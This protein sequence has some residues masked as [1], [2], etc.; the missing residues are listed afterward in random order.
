LHYSLT[1]SFLCAGA[2]SH[3]H[4]LGLDQDGQPKTQADG[5]VGQV[6]ARKA[7]GVVL[8]MIKESKI[9]GRGI[10]LAGQPGSGKTALAMGKWRSR[11]Q[12][13]EKERKKS[14][15]TSFFLSLYMRTKIC[16]PFQPRI[17]T[18]KFRE[19]SSRYLFHTVDPSK[20][21]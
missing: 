16:L 1:S 15:S 20:P 19:P 9:A 21:Q 5:L 3:I 11:K 12:K 2:H 13:K 17:D 10:L 4:G 6:T 8:R 14:T 18:L 7:I